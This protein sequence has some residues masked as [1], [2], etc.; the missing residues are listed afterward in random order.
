MCSCTTNLISL[1][2]D[3]KTITGFSDQVSFFL[4]FNYYYESN[5]IAPV[6]MGVTA[7][8]IRSITTCRCHQRED[9]QLAS[10]AFGR[11][12]TREHENFFNILWKGKTKRICSILIYKQIQS[13]VEETSQYVYA[14]SKSLPL[15]YLRW[16]FH[17]K[18]HSCRENWTA[19]TQAGKCHNIYRIAEDCLCLLFLEFCRGT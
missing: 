16:F 4:V 17:W 9:N 5:L 15:V 11:H 19:R 1:S 13:L 3:G 6:Y 18:W 8:W 10:L 2:D 14:Y 12:A 7:S